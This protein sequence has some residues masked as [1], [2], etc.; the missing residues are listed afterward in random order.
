MEAQG[1]TIENNILYQDNK[2]TI[3]LAKNGRMMAGKNSNHIKNLFLITDKAAHKELKIQHKGTK[4]IWADM[5]TKP[6]QEMTFQV[7]RGQV[8]GIPVEYDDDMEQLRKHIYFSYPRLNQCLYHGMTQMFS[9]KS[10][11]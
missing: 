11:L 6:F 2:S 3:F 10:K 4:E 7:M 8:M 5:N 1:Y 9:R